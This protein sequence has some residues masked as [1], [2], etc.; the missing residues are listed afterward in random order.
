MDYVPVVSGAVMVAL[1]LVALHPR[2]G[3]VLT[4]VLG[5]TAALVM[6][7]ASVLLFPM[8]MGMYGYAL[9]PSEVLALLVLLALTALRSRPWQIALVA[10][11]AYAATLSDYLRE[12][13]SLSLSSPSMLVAVG[14][15]PGLYLRWREF[16]RQTAMERARAQER[17]A[18]ARDLHDVVAHE[19]TGIVV[20][21]QALRH[22]AERDPEAVRALLPE[23]EAAGA[24]ALESM[25]G[26]VS[27]L[28]D[29]DDV[30]LAPDIAEGLSRLKAAPGDGRPRVAVR[31]EGD[32][33]ALP[34]AVGTTV[35]RIVQ[36]AVTNALRYARGATLVDA[37]VRT[38][39]D[40][41]RVEVG[42]D[43]REGAG[44]V[45][46]G[47]GLLGMA[48]RTRLLGGDLSAGPRGGGTGWDVRAWL[49]LE[50]DA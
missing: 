32:V 49:P 30:S 21:A 35:L 44:T 41:V 26:M 25:R 14:L 16:Q 42:D 34:T 45:G 19:V 46:G 29:T 5:G 38:G 13:V 12:P 31:C 9:A 3:R 15:A 48:E 4:A 1:T 33:N 8:P 7:L 10:L 22:V 6:A 37:V 27:R 17:L 2:A 23:I 11:G 47:F 20:Q 43:G 50:G 24:R 40:G 28:R 18:I 39:P 36:E